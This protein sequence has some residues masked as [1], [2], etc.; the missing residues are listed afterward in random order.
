MVAQVP[1]SGWQQ[2]RASTCSFTAQRARVV[3]VLVF[4]RDRCQVAC[5]SGPQVDCDLVGLRRRTPT[6][7]AK[8]TTGR[9]SAGGYNSGA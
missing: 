3:R 5:E 8:P 4:P 2:P 9:S 6:G 7:R 1:S